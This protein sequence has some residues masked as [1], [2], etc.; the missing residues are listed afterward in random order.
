MGFGLCLIVS[1]SEREGERRRDLPERGDC[2]GE[3]EEAVIPS[4]L[5]RLTGGG[6]VGRRVPSVC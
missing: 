5:V 6:P 3:D 1:G 2:E 4:H